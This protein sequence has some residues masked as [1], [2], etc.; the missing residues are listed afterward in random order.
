MAASKILDLIPKNLI[1][2]LIEEV[3]ELLRERSKE[4]EKPEPEAEVRKPS[5]AELDK[6][7]GKLL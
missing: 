3:Q 7:I 4:I 5:K 6:I 2:P 1:E